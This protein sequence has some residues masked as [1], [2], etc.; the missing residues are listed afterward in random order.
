MLDGVGRIVSIAPTKFYNLDARGQVDHMH[1][2]LQSTNRFLE[3]MVS[4]DLSIG[5]RLYN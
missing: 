2:I 5:Y 4:T 3:P 1:N